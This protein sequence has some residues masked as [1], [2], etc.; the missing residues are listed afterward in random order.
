MVLGL[1]S[2]ERKNDF[3]IFQNLFTWLLDYKAEMKSED[4]DYL[5]SGGQGYPF[6]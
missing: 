4:I 5:Y 2:L 3:R 6:C 1:A